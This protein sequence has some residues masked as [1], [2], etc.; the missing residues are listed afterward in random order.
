MRKLLITALLF[1]IALV[2]SPAA[3]RTAYAPTPQ[4]GAGTGPRAGEVSLG[5]FVAPIR[6]RGGTASGPGGADTLKGGPGCSIQCITGGVAYGRGPDARLVVTT[7]S[8]ATIR[9]VVSRAGY[10]RQIVSDAGK[11]SFSADF[12]DLAADTHYDAF[13]SA[14]DGAGHMANRSGSFRTL[15][16]NAHV[17][18]NEAHITEAPFGDEPYGAQIWFEGNPVSTFSAGDADDGVLH[19]GAQSHG[20]DDTDRYLDLAVE[21]TQYE[22]TDDVCEVTFDADLPATGWGDCEFAASVWFPGGDLALDL[23]DRPSGAAVNDY[24]IG[25]TLVLPGGEA[26]PVGYGYPL[27]FTVLAAVHVT[28]T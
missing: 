4:P 20:A 3:A 2:A 19:L 6:T 28:W 15:K 25:E 8:P 13:V 1:A 10:Y 11:T 24:W 27:K 22:D 26:L 5:S 16:R 12:D 18:F 14:V 9:I 21:L 23:D 7:D 17:V